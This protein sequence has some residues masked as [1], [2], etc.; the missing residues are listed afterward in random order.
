LGLFI[1]RDL[2]RQGLLGAGFTP[3]QIDASAL[4]DDPRLAGRLVGPI[5]DRWGRIVSFW[6]RHPEGH[7]PK[8]L[9]KGRWKEEAGLFGLDVALHPA[10]GGSGDL[11]VVQRILDAILLQSRGLRRVAAI[12]GPPSDLDRRRWQ[13]LAA[14]GLRRLLLVRGHPVDVSLAPASGGARPL[15]AVQGRPVEVCPM[16][17]CEATT[18]FCFD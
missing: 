8:F 4:A 9:F 3:E 10:S 7:P 5:R 13:R 15:R 1:E 2:V 17:H 16:H 6:A 12:G 11:I 14:L 18:C